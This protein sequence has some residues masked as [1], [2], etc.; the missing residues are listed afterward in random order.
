MKAVSAFAMSFAF[1]MFASS[2]AAYA[3]AAN[4]KDEKAKKEETK[5]EDSLTCGKELVGPWLIEYGPNSWRASDLK[6]EIEW[7]VMTT[8]DKVTTTKFFVEAKYQRQ[9]AGG[10]VYGDEA[11]IWYNLPEIPL[12]NSHGKTYYM[13]GD[14]L[15]HSYHRSVSFGTKRYWT[16][17]NE[18]WYPIEDKFNTKVKIKHPKASRAFAR[19]VNKEPTEMRIELYAPNWSSDTPIAIGKILDMAGLREAAKIAKKRV[20]TLRAQGMECTLTEEPNFDPP[21]K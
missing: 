21:E 12:Q 7:K 2:P 4:E 13:F 5:D 18:F 9:T 19:A 3:G 1:S 16:D 8:M 14:E 6:T 17:K 20:M 11:R 10:Y 15:G